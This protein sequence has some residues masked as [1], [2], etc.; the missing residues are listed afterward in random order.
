MSNIYLFNY[1][2]YFNRIVKK[3]IS[4]E[5]YGTPVYSLIESESQKVNFNMSDELRTSHVINY[6][7]S[8]GDYFIV[9]DSENNITSR[10]FVIENKKV[11]G[12]QHTLYLKRDVIVDFYDN[13]VRAPSLINRAM[14]KDINS[15][16]IFNSEGFSFNQIKQKEIL[17]KDA[18][19]SAWYALYFAKNAPTKTATFTTGNAE[20]DLEISTTLDSSA[21]APGTYN[22]IA[23]EN[24]FFKCKPKWNDFLPPD[25]AMEQVILY[26]DGYQ[27]TQEFYQP[28]NN[29]EVT[30]FTDSWG[31]VKEQLET[32]FTGQ[33]NNLCNK[34]K[35]SGNLTDANKKILDQLGNTNSILIKDSS[36]NIYK[37]T[38]NITSVYE[39]ETT[40]TSGDFVDY[41][42]TLI[43]GTTLNRVYDWGTKSFSYGSTKY[44]YYVTAVLQTSNTLTWTLFDAGKTTTL[45]ADYNVILIPYNQVE[46]YVN[47]DNNIISSD[48]SKRL[49]DSIIREYGSTGY[50]Y[51][52][53]LIPYFPY[54]SII[55]R[56]SLSLNTLYLEHDSLTPNI[57]NLPTS[58]YYAN[59][60]SESETI[61]I[62]Y[63]N[64]CKFSFDIN[65][66]TPLKIGEY[67][68]NLIINKKI[69]NECNLY[70]LCSPNYNGIFEFSVAKN[71]GVEYFN[72][73]VTMRPYNPY[74]HLNPN[75]KSIYGSDFDDARGL[76]CQGDFSLPVV[77]D[78]FKQYE[79]QNK[80]YLNTFNRQIEH[81]DFEFS[82]QQVE[83]TFG[84]ITGSMGAGI[85]GAYA[86][87]KIGGPIG[88]GIGGAFSSI[89][90]AIGGIAD[91]S[92]LKE[93]Q[94]EA[95]D[96]AVDNFKYQLGNIKALAY[97]VNKIT[98]LTNNNKIWPFIEVYS[99]TDEE[100]LILYNKIKYNSM[101]VNS[102]GKIEDYIQTTKTFI[103]ASIIR[104]EEI[105]AQTNIANEIYDEI[106]KGVYI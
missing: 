46:A 85:S 95:K 41:M 70:R 79:Y 102:I 24:I 22:Y 62:L 56:N 105:S 30:R 69:E 3:E 12:N 59:P 65:L 88:A 28:S 34:I 8:D 40:V 83:A 92:I 20:Y 94:A 84:A 25:I 36:N 52:I 23:P 51:D 66:T 21:Y 91:V 58:Y 27:V 15:P 33:Y 6:N 32:A 81:M 35:L 96:L 76:I 104:L 2:N 4:L 47:S 63:A 11:R 13:V 53:Q 106:L 71:N 90:S 26:S 37:V 93:R 75:F 99:S 9:T 100:G 31:T 78:A 19:E 14:I 80:N 61:I 17:L 57:P 18:S 67:S 39:E 29:H 43:N 55:V 60:I 73:D 97:S 77:T 7:G 10:W 103:S 48:N 89:A 72:V 54:Q 5:N 50:L 82:K 64:T 68:N 49:V 87:A 74:I 44:T 101:N 86:G 98:P 1:N 38:L 16:L 42:K 45:D